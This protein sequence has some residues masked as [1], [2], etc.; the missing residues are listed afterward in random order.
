MTIRLII[1]GV[2]LGGI[3][4]LLVLVNPSSSDKLLEYFEG[5]DDSDKTSV[6]LRYE[7]KQGQ[8]LSF[9]STAEVISTLSTGRGPGGGIMKMKLVP[10]FKVESVDENGIATIEVSMSELVLETAAGMGSRRVEIT[11][12]EIHA[13]DDMG[14]TRLEEEDYAVKDA[15]TKPFSVTVTPRGE[16]T[17]L[18]SATDVNLQVYQFRQFMSAFFFVLPEEEIIAGND[19]KYEAP[20]MNFPSVKVHDI[21]SVFLGYKDFEGERC[22][23]LKLN[24]TIEFGE[25]L[26][27]NTSGANRGFLKYAGGLVF[28]IERGL[29]IVMLRRQE[30]SRTTMSKNGPILRGVTDE[31]YVIKLLSSSEKR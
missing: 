19:W 13:Y 24:L 6:L 14:E 30:G 26:E 22:A 27:E 9:E 5:V 15:L 18:D 21:R 4:T 23:V 12:D 10:T 1:V 16:V 2:I 7:F 29:P 11:P 28:S 8:E 31:E 3:A 17:F 20:E 25:N